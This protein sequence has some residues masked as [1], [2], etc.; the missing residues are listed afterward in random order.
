MK[1]LGVVVVVVGIAI[2]ALAA[3]APSGCRFALHYDPTELATDAALQ[4]RFVKEAQE[5]EAQ[6][7]RDGVGV[8]PTS[9]LTY[10]GRTIDYTTGEAAL[11][12][13][14]SA[15]SKEALH[16][17]ILALALTGRAAWP[18]RA[19]AV[20][21]LA[22]K[23]KTYLAFDARYPGFGGFLPWFIANA[24]GLTPTRDWS[25]RVPSL[26]NGQLAWSLVAAA[27]ALREAGEAALAAQ[28]EAYADKLAA[29][30]LVVFHEG[31][32]R[33]RAVA[34]IVDVSRK[35]FPGNYYTDNPCGNPCYLD[36]PYEGE[37]LAWFADLRAPW[38]NASE[39][40]EMWIFKRTKLQAAEFVTPD[41]PITVQ[42]GW[43]FSSHEQCA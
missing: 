30:V 28:Y 36:D 32:G 39:R 33:I 4:E 29:N 21:T 15:A 37:L 20:D 2:A 6:F 43:W 1:C 42:R 40:E 3:G 12:W 38:T 27:V 7:M 34:N 31:R 35:P 17:N 25:T 13:D 18:S 5:W 8:D 11:V 14:W 41:G 9:G 23:I 26:D 22:R 19:A 10:N 24:S 16:L